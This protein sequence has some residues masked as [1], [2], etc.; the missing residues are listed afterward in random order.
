MLSDGIGTWLKRH[1]SKFERY[2]RCIGIAVR[3]KAG[4]GGVLLDNLALNFAR[5]RKMPIQNVA[6]V[7]LLV[8]VIEVDH[9][10]SPPPSVLREK[11]KSRLNR[12]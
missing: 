2:Q 4:W 11:N 5:G 8:N 12:L 6:S 3:L 7:N 1:R 10:S 9:D